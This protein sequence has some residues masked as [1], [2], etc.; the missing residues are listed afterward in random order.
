VREVVAALPGAIILA[1]K[2]KLPHNPD[3]I[4]NNKDKPATF[5]AL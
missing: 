3:M 4:N 1:V 2:K 5:A